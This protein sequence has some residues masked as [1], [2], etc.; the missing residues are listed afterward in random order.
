MGRLERKPT[1]MG[2]HLRTTSGD[3][4]VVIGMSEPASAGAAA[5]RT[6]EPGAAFVVVDSFTPARLARLPN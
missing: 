1:A 2:Q 4:L 6:K 5:A 3:G